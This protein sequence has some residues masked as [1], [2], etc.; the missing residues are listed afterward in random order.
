MINGCIM[1]IVRKL[2]HKNIV[3]GGLI[4]IGGLWGIRSALSPLSIDVLCDQKIA[5]ATRTEIR[6]LLAQRSVW[7]LGARGVLKELEA[8]YKMVSSVSIRTTS[9]RHAILRV[10][11]KNPL[12]IIAS[13]QPNHQEYV[14]CVPPAMLPAGYRKKVSAEQSTTSSPVTKTPE[15]TLIE[16]RYFSEEALAGLPIFLVD[17]SDFNGAIH[18]A[19]L[20]ECA[21]DIDNAVFDEY[22]VTWKAKSEIILHNMRAPCVIIADIASIQDKERLSAVKRIYEAEQITYKD[23][24]KADIRLRE[25]IVC[26]QLDKPY[27]V[28]SPRGIDVAVGREKVT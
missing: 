19:E 8:M 24:I 13:V 17:G 9:S 25:S 1:T 4:L 18:H 22:R 10:K 3:I 20:L 11:A 28:Q 26:S 7:S 12:L 27:H 21:R 15:I 5:P 2:F 6:A 14:L 23:G 16:K